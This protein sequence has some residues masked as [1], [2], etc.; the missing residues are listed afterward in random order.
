MVSDKRTDIED[1][2]K[3]L[4]SIIKLLVS[5][6]FTTEEREAEAESDNRPSTSAA[7]I[8]DLREHGILD[9]MRGRGLDVSFSLQLSSR[10]QMPQLRI[11]LSDEIKILR[12][13]GR[14]L[15]DLASR[16]HRPI[17]LEYLEVR[18]VYFLSHFKTL[19][20]LDIWMPFDT[21]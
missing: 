6:P 7:T 2:I 11:R 17:L 12:D 10:S 14:E 8:V 20:C 18:L 13:S 21:T 5:D 16:C 4:E 9:T 19:L 1:N 15:A 3:S